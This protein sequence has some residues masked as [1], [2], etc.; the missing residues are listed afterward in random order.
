M[1]CNLTTARKLVEQLTLKEKSLLCVG[2]D[3]W[4]TYPIERLNIPSVWMADGPHGLRKS[5]SSEAGG[6][7]NSEP[8][9]CF[10]TAS[11]LASSWD[12]ELILQ[13]GVAIG[14]EAQTR[15]V[16]FILGPGVNMKRDPRGG[17]NFEYYSEDPILSG[18]MAVAFIKG[19]QSQGVGA[20][21]KHFA[22][23]NQEFAR[24]Y[25]DS[26]LDERT[27]REIYLPAFEIAVKEGKPWTIM[28]SYNPIN[29]VYAA[30]N[31]YLLQNILKEEWEYDG[32]VVSD[33]GAVNDRP[34]GVHAGMHLEMPGSGDVNVIKIVDAVQSGALEVSRLDEVVTQLLSV[35]LK[36]H[37]QRKPEENFSADTH[38]QLARQAASESV[39]LLKNDQALLPLTEGKSL[40]VIGEFAKQ[41][42][43]QG[44]GSSQVVPTK[45]DSAWDALTDQNWEMQ[46]ASGYKQDGSTNNLLLKESAELAAKAD[47]ALIFAGLPNCFES[48][49]FDREHIELPEGHN[50]LIEMVSS[51]QSKTVVILT[52]GAAITM[53]WV[54]QVSAIVEGWLAG[55]AGGSAIVDVL[56]GQVN[57]SGK[58]SETFPL[59]LED[60]PAFLNWPGEQGQI[61]YR[62]GLFIGYRHYD[63]KKIEPLFPFGHGLSYTRFQYS[64]LKLS[65]E[66]I[67]ESSDLKISLDVSNIGQNKGKEVVQLYIHPQ[68]SRLKRPEQ[69]LKG[70]EKIELDPGETIKVHLSLSSRDFSY[71]DPEVRGWLMESGPSEIRIGSSSRDIRLEAVVTISPKYSAPLKFTEL[72]PLGSWLNHPDVRDLVVPV[73]DELSKQHGDHGEDEDASAMMEAMFKDLPLIKLVQFTQGLFSESKVKAIVKKANK[74]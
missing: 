14:V 44:A 16:Q 63:I 4:T 65:A 60:C 42:R 73:I 51:V 12:P 49:S 71:Y 15:G 29:G 24:M 7:G 70:F 62:E 35:I 28:C 19:I 52:N 31:L 64:N 6:I 18:K 47:I 30:E 55:Q 8:A 72:T 61:Q 66:E 67:D 54:N 46:F 25:F 38:H 34:S 3:F 17:R 32:V 68:Q 26:V 43:I 58:L 21:L 13:L 5:T 57:P 36:A 39:V 23:N 41:P 20:S 37:K 10:P 11:A 40:A 74:R 33:W 48:E 69:E 22:V 59:R 50:R 56:T 45:I 53:P 1:D 27:L 9:T 2:R